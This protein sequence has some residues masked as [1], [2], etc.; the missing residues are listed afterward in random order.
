[1]EKKK[2]KPSPPQIPNPTTNFTIIEWKSN[3][4]SLMY[5]GGGCFFKIY[6]YIHTYNNG[7]M[8]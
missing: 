5:G 3:I 2:K 1:M 7:F 6:I 4:T 8:H